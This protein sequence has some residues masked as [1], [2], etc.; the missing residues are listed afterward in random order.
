MNLSTFPAF[1]AKQEFY[2]SWHFR[3]AVMLF[4]TFGRLTILCLH[5]AHLSAH[6]IHDIPDPDNITRILRYQILPKHHLSPNTPVRRQ[7]P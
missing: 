2:S 1:F 6:N 7:C 5:V 4:Y 3:L